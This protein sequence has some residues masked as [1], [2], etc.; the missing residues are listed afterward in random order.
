M[1]Q[2]RNDVTAALAVLLALGPLSG[3]A[4]PPRAAA[5]PA[6]VAA[7]PVSAEATQ[8]D[9]TV[10]LPSGATVKVAIDWAVATAADGLVLE[11]PEKQLRV[12]LVE[13]DASAGL[14]A[15]VSTAWARRRPGFNRSELAA[16]DSPGREGWALFRWSRYT[17][18][19]EEGRRRPRIVYGRP[20]RCGGAR[21]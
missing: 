12:D 17:T 6:A 4:S 7:G 20:S 2:L 18:S 8:T 5:P 13:V 19:P 15:A 16:S 3:C 1:L 10:T 14:S 21:R 9:R 11:D